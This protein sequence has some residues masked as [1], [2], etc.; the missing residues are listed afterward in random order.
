MWDIWGLLLCLAIVMALNAVFAQVVVSL[1]KSNVVSLITSG[2]YTDGA[3]SFQSLF[4]LRD[5]QGIS[6]GAALRYASALPCVV[7]ADAAR[8]LLQPLFAGGFSPLLPFIMAVGAVTGLGGVG[9][10]LIA[11]CLSLLVA[12]YGLFSNPY[13]FA[14]DLP[15]ARYTMALFALVSVGITLVIGRI[16]QQ[17]QDLRIREKQLDEV[18]ARLMSVTDSAPVM[19][20]QFDVE[21]RV[22]FCNRHYAALWDSSPEL[23]LGRSLRDL[24]G[25]ERFA[26]IRIHSSSALLGESVQ[27]EVELTPDKTFLVNYTPER[28]VAGQVLGYVASLV[29]ISA[30]KAME[31]ALHEADMRKDVFIATLAHELRNPLAAIRMASHMLGVASIE[32]AAVEKSR[33]I[34]ARQ[35]T[36]MSALLDDLLDVSRVTR[37]AMELNTTAVD[38]RA[39]IDAAVETAQ[40]LISTK[41]HI[42]QLDFPLEPPEIE[43][44]AMRLTQIIAN[45]LTNAAKYTDAGGKI[46]LSVSPEADRLSIRVRDNGIGIAPPMLPKVFEM[47]AQDKTAMARSEGGMGIGLALVKGLVQAHGGEV[48]ANSAGLGEGCEFVVKL[49]YGDARF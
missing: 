38:L 7:A 41:K 36:Q 48:H 22:Q 17:T 46:I 33:Q 23:L 34:V 1:L 16:R 44:D 42:L 24:A 35:V 15:T 6:L 9:P 43:A 14:P 2:H 18:N 8:A 31:A 4:K 37:G 28:G 5:K 13:I 25:E 40:P 39:V 45:L 11:T 30:R 27:F 47:F 32:G 21:E 19:I 49:P 12:V 29:D 26:A 10:G 3:V 20:A